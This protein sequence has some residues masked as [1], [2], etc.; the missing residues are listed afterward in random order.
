MQR[1][2]MHSSSAE[3]GRWG[4][5]GGEEGRIRPWFPASRADRRS[6][7]CFPHTASK[8]PSMMQLQCPPHHFFRLPHFSHT[9]NGHHVS[10]HLD[11][12]SESSKCWRRDVAH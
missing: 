1:S 4:R 12:L 3:G 10:L 6:R 2:P 8:R 7:M 5:D 9:W 11:C